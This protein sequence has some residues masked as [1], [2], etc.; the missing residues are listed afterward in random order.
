MVR[1]GLVMMLGLPLSIMYNR[2]NKLSGYYELDEN[3]V[4]LRFL[5]PVV[6][7]TI[8]G[9]VGVLGGSF[10]RS[11]RSSPED[12][13]EGSRRQRHGI[14]LGISVRDELAVRCGQLAVQQ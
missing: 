1:Y 3:G 9:R 4:P 5:S 14:I 2:V 8:K 7:E 11:T 13:R 6:P 10:I 12:G